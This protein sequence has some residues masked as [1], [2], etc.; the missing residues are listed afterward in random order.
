MYE[1]EGERGKC[2]AICG[3]LQFKDVI[4]PG[5]ACA[6]QQTFHLPRETGNGHF[7]CD[8]AAVL[9]IMVIKQVNELTLGHDFEA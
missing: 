5:S 8:S 9:T 3:S 2:M 7:S 6:K 1:I 4:L